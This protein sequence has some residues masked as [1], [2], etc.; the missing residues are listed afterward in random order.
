MCSS[1]E[2]LKQEINQTAEAEHD[3]AKWKLGVTA[4]LGAAAF[5][6]GKEGCSPSYWVLLF[7]P[8]VCAYVDLFS[9]QYELRVLVLAR[10]IREHGE[11]APVLQAYE[12]T[13]EAERGNRVFSLGNAAELWS[14]LAASLL[15]P[16]LYL[17][18]DKFAQPSADSLLISR[19][20]AFSVWLF[21]ILLIVY[22]WV[23][24][25]FKSR[26]ISKG[27]GSR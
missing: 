7:V 10:F 23:D 5:G 1:V 24:L 3:L 4:A 6:F 2:L 15:G 19:P 26:K 20:A 9:Y 16:V 21:G 14:S 25:Q 17:L 11:S 13:C 22:L 27:T 8:F 18:H 12:K